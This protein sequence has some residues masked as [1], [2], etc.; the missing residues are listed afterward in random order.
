V[1][2]ADGDTTLQV[3]YTGD[4]AHLIEEHDAIL[5]DLSISSVLVFL[6]VSTL[7]IAYFRS[8][9]G[10]LVVLAGV[11]PGLLFTFA[12]GH[13]LV[14]HLN[15]NTAFLGS[16]IAGN[17]IN[18]PLLFL[19]YYRARSPAEPMG[20]SLLQAARNSLPGTLGAA[21]TASAAYAGL[22][23]SNFR[24]FSQF[25]WLGGA[26]MLVT[27]AMTFVAVPIAISLFKPPR[28]GEGRP[29]QQRLT[30]LFASKR[31]LRVAAAPS[32]RLAVLAVQ[33]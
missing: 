6:L 13:L 14:G 24:G 31:A 33:G 5:S 20:E 30:P 2:P 29:R 10:V 16:I 22:A 4:V 7:I 25:G 3:E 9:R 19:A 26:G 12:V 21:A 18:Y 28:L 32:W 8:A 23:V 15:S 11:V 1:N 17:G 27:W